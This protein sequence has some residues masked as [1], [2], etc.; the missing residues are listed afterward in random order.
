M[1]NKMCSCW[2]YEEVFHA[3]RM[4]LVQN[5]YCELVVG[6]L[7]LLFFCASLLYFIISLLSLAFMSFVKRGSDANVF[8]MTRAFAFHKRFK[9][10]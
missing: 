10:E 2:S 9:P 8:F 4:Q 6:L 7:M 5:R 3:K 1:N